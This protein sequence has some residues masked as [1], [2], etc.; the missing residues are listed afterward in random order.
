MCRLYGVANPSQRVAVLCGCGA[1][2]T[3]NPGFNGDGGPAVSAY[4]YNPRF[5]VA[6]PAGI[7]VADGDNNRIRLIQQDGTIQVYTCMQQRQSCT[8][9]RAAAINRCINHCICIWER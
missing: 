5:V 6:Q 7:F 8:P 4:L 3:N 1:G 2:V 9:A